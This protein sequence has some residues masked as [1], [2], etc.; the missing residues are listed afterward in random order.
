M[1]RRLKP[2]PQQCQPLWLLRRGDQAVVGA[3]ALVALA[4][5]GLHLCVPGES[6][7][8][9]VEFEQLPRH[10]I[11]FEIDI[12]QADW[13]ELAQLPGIGATLARRIVEHRQTHGP[14]AHP[15]DLRQVRGIGPK[16]LEGIRPHLAPLAHHPD[17][18][19]QTPGVTSSTE[20]PA[21]SRK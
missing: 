12:N 4:G 19:S 8:P 18:R 21:G 17:G 15:E 5:L 2:Q 6:G 13:P 16:K 11:R 9:W 10:T 14:F 20:F 1:L 3:L 7:A